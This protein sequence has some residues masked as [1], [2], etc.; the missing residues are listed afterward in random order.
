MSLV[1]PSRVAIAREDVSLLESVFDQLSDEHREVITLHRLVG[2]DHD[3]IGR[4]MG[5][6]AA[7]S[8]V[9]LHRALARLGRLMATARDSG[10]ETKGAE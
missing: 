8:R 7:A 2:L 5:R 6:T 4:R 10:D 9:L 1:S 3:E